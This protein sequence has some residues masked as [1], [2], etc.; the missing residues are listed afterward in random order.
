MK[1][2]LV[3]FFALFLFSCGNMSKQNATDSQNDSL[4]AEETTAETAKPMPPVYV[5]CD[6][7]GEKFLLRQRFDEDEKPSAPDSLNK[8]KFVIYKRNIYLCK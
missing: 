3:P 8:Y 1:K 7:Y 6:V 5:V 4:W 2:L